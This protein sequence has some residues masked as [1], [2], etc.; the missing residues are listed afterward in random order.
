MASVYRALYGNPLLRYPLQLRS[1][2]LE[3]YNIIECHLYLTRREMYVKTYLK[4]NAHS[5]KHKIVVTLLPRHRSR[6]SKTSRP[7]KGIR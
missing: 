4:Y 2:L 1:E 3:N 5:I 6:R 7:V